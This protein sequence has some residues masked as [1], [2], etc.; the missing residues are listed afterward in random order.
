MPFTVEVT[1][2]RF[3]SAAT[4]AF[5]WP[6]AST[7]KASVTTSFLVATSSYGCVMTSLPA[8]TAAWYHGRPV[9]S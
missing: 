3:T 9:G 2:S 7:G 4:T 5:S 6:L 8:L 1:A